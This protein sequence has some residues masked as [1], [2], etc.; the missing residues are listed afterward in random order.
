MRPDPVAWQDS[1]AILIGVSTYRDERLP[2]IVAAAN[3]LQQL[4]GVV[5][6]PHLCGWPAD[7]VTILSDPSDSRTV[8][9]QIRQLTQETR[10]VLLLYYVGHGTL[11]PYSELCLSVT[12]TDADDPDLTGVEYSR[13]RSALIDSPARVKMVILDCCYSGRAIRTLANQAT[14][15]ADATEIAGTYTLTASDLAA[16]VPPPEKQT[17]ACTS[18]TSELV[19]LIRTGIPDKDDPLTLGTL[20][21]ELRRRLRARGLPDPNQ[22]GTDT[23]HSFAFTRNAATSQHGITALKD[24]VPSAALAH[25]HLQPGLG[26]ETRVGRIPGKSPVKPNELYKLN[27]IPLGEGTFSQVFLAEHRIT[28]DQVALKRAR[29]N[30]NARARIQREIEVQLLLSPHPHIMSIIDFDPGLRWYTMPVAKGTLRDLRDGLNEDDLASIINDLSWALEAAHEQDL[31]H[32]DISP[33]NILALANEVTH[34]H[35]WV[36]AD[37]G[38]VRR[39]YGS[40]SARLTRTGASAGTPGFDAPE[41]AN[42]AQNASAAADIYSLGRVAAWFLTKKMPSSGHP[43][44][45]EGPALHWRMFVKACTEND[46]SDRVTSMPEMREALT[47]V[48]LLQED[49]PAQRIRRLLENTTKDHTDLKALMEYAQAYS[50]DA[51]LYIDH[52]AWV[53]TGKLQ[54]W[55]VDHPS[56]ASQ[57]AV[58]MAQHVR[59]SHWGDRDREHIVFPLTFIFTIL[60]SLTEAHQFAQAM[61][62]ATCYFAAEAS[63]ACDR[64][65][66]R[67]VQWLSDLNAPADAVIARALTS[68]LDLVDYYRPG[69][70]PRS[71]TLKAI[72]KM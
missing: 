67:T 36:L 8:A 32:R 22:R 20:Y 1:R 39:A 49:P 43:L 44:L 2:K 28:G 62:V 60:Q 55:A 45:P 31:V 6:S 11:T 46:L 71:P 64:Q 23:A 48:F 26:T 66:D 69:M 51:G 17:D 37:W 38:M 15:V 53:P 3:S 34:Q 47:N 13:I 65:R 7:R 54:A 30:K 42:D 16:H 10:D 35:Q 72:F 57:I 27:R 9:K 24:V 63:W 14:V 50:S 25:Q 41:L 59:T 5:T 52:V 61:D 18:F 68:Q 56:L 4:R 70:T 29:P 33:M 21:I 40:N 12:D 19:D 58:H